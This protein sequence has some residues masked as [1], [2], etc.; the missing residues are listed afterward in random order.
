MHGVLVAV[1]TLLS[2]G[3]AYAQR[4]EAEIAFNRGRE[5][6]AAGQ[7]GKACASFETALRLEPT[8]GTL[9]NLGLC[10]EKLGK[11]ATAWAQLNQV[12]KTDTNKGRG[13]DAASRAAEI[14]PRLTRFKIVVAEPVSG[15]VIQRDGIDVTTLV[16]QVVPVD[17]R[18]YVFEARAPGKTSIKLDV[19]LDREGETIEVAIPAWP[20]SPK[21]VPTERYPMQLALRPI[22]VPSGMVEVVAAN[23]VSTSASEFEQV[24][25]EGFVGG[26]VGIRKLELALF[27]TFH[28]RHAEVMMPRPNPMRSV[29]G[30]ATYA[31][32]PIMA[33]RLEYARLHPIGDIG[34]GS[35]LRLVVVRKQPLATRLAAAGSAG[36]V[37]Q[38]RDQQFAEARNELVA[39]AEIGVQVTA[40]PRLSF[41]GGAAFQLNLGGALFDHTVG[42][43]FAVAAQ[44]SL[45]REID[46]VARILVGLLPAVPEAEGGGAND[47]RSYMIAL[48][49]R[50]R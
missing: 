32:T 18:S 12:A 2:T 48:N 9:Y 14:E 11:L 46:I 5:L 19:A 31:V 8:N 29:G 6:M 20:V 30:R 22:T 38:Q 35:D 17:P 16:G 47:L 4:A 39:E 49:W 37:F 44:I 25:I 24:P 45:N 26:R 40:L 41:E 15:M 34:G 33:G 23:V 43:G 50:L 3:L 10:H 1:V 27:T 13:A 42:L 21:P 7:Y 36:F 28:L